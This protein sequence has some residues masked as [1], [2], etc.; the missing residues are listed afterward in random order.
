LPLI[1]FLLYKGSWW[2]AGLLAW[3]AASS[4][5]EYINIT[6]KGVPGIAWLA[7]IGAGVTPFF[8]V[9]S[10][11]HATELAAAGISVL[12][13]ATW[14]YHLLEGPL[15]DAPV[16]TAQIMMGAVYGAGGMA[17]LMA[18]RQQDDGMWWLVAALVITWAN[19]SAAYFAGRLFGRNKL[20]PEVSPNKTWEGF[21]GGMVGGIGGLFIERHW[22]FP[23]MTVADCLVLG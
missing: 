5:G 21:F 1:I 16:R 19:D 3:G 7:I 14:G 22:F 11:F 15:E 13:L 4:T 2:T 8:V 20:Y 18:V 6:L 23:S 12:M 10:P 9:V 17:A